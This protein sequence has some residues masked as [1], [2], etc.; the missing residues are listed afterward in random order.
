MHCKEGEVTPDHLI[1]DCESVSSKNPFEV[2]DLPP[3]NPLQI[4]QFTVT[5]ELERI[6]YAIISGLLKWGTTDRSA[7][8]TPIFQSNAITA[9]KCLAL[10][11]DDSKSR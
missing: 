6:M 9:D 3:L 11:L 2:E 5:M 8:V 10:K 1:T 4:V 7:M